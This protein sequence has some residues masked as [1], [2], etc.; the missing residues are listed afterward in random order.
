VVKRMTRMMAK[1]RA[2]NPR[3]IHSKS[4][5]A[6]VGSDSEANFSRVVNVVFDEDSEAP[7]EGVG[8]AEVC[9][10]EVRGVDTDISCD[11][12]AG[13]LPTSLGDALGGELGAV[14]GVDPGGALKEKQFVAVLEFTAHFAYKLRLLA[15]EY[16]GPS[17]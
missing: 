1:S 7:M 8:M 2:A 15:V 3:I 6:G 16:E 10:V 14:V 5:G 13:V 17:A 12:S 4:D 11:G 9:D